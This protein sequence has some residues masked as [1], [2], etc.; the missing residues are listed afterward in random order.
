MG[1]HHQ[2]TRGGSF[3]ETTD[4]QNFIR[5]IWAKARQKGVEY[6]WE[7]DPDWRELL[8]SNDEIVESMLQSPS[9]FAESDS[10]SAVP[11]INKTSRYLLHIMDLVLKSHHE[12]WI[13]EVFYNYKDGL[14]RSLSEWVQ[15]FVEENERAFAD[16]ILQGVPERLMPTYLLFLDAIATIA[17]P[18]YQS[19]LVEQAKRLI[20]SLSQ[21]GVFKTLAEVP[22]QHFDLL[23][24]TT[25]QQSELTDDEKKV[26]QI[27]TLLDFLGSVDD[28]GKVLTSVDPKWTKI[29]TNP[30]G[31]G[32]RLS[33]LTKALV[34]ATDRY[35]ELEPNAI[36]ALESSKGRLA[37]RWAE[38]RSQY[39]D[40]KLA[41]RDL[42]E[43][44]IAE[45][46]LLNVVFSGMDPAEIIGLEPFL[47]RLSDPDLGDCLSECTK[48]FNYFWGD[49]GLYSL[50]SVNEVKV[51]AQ[52]EIEK[53]PEI[54]HLHLPI[55]DSLGP[56]QIKWK[57]NIAS[58][59]CD[60][61][62]AAEL[63]KR[64]ANSIGLKVGDARLGFEIE[65]EGAFRSN[66]IVS[67]GET[68]NFGPGFD[69]LAKE[70]RA[71]LKQVAGS[72][73]KGD[74]SELDRDS[75]GSV[76]LE[77]LLK[78]EWEG[79]SASLSCD[80]STAAELCIRAAESRG[81]RFTQKE[82][83]IIVKGRFWRNNDARLVVE[84]SEEGGARSNLS[85]KKGETWH[86]GP[87]FSGLAKEFRAALEQVV[88][89][90]RKGDG[91][92]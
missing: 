16:M 5:H 54:K 50:L 48:E 47:H 24:W 53:R 64:A 88:D 41:E 37:R 83:K 49:D 36:P 90:E 75:R 46:Y 77:G 74:E 4:L 55:R 60:E 23:A 72:E 18:T 7:N 89:A 51:I 6:G 38:W 91:S 67:K 82:E 39:C 69:D 73:R 22:E 79:N 17:R 27:S 14:S 80:E 78:I 86:Y 92:E 34:S 66:L 59:R 71:A 70:F 11:T 85:I 44:K 32:S 58:L 35:Y 81:L 21:E 52:K 25:G 43:S 13:H 63:L 57:G 31:W 2:E 26:Q 29:S 45:E 9:S 65:E 10:D 1:Q 28:D 56:I 20:K 33:E 40:L 42:E 76:D 62:T 8:R 84:I 68:W 19:D 3:P 30:E 61:S 87:G 15:G 12:E